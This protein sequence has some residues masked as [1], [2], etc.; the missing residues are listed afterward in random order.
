MAT[1]KVKRSEI[2]GIYQKVNA[3]MSM[4]TPMELSTPIGKN[5]YRIERAYKEN[6]CWSRWVDEG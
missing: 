6:Q 4:E 2:S 1:L 5:I 3:L